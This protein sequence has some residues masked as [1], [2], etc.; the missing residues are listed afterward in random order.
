MPNTIING[1]IRPTFDDIRKHLSGTDPRQGEKH[2]RLD[3]DR[4]LHL[5]DSGKPSG[6]GPQALRARQEKHRQ[7]FH[8]VVEAIDRQLRRTEGGQTIHIGSGEDVLRDV[9][10]E[11]SFRERRISVNDLGRIARRLEDV[12]RAHRDALIDRIVDSFAGQLGEDDPELE[13]TLRQKLKDAPFPGVKPDVLRGFAKGENDWQA[14]PPQDLAGLRDDLERLGPWQA[15]ARHA[16]IHDVSIDARA[17]IAY[18]QLTVPD[19]EGFTLQAILDNQAARRAENRPDGAIIGRHGKI[20]SGGAFFHYTTH[21]VANCVET[22]DKVH[23]SVA[24]EQLARAWNAIAPILIDNPDAIKQFKVSDL[25]VARQEMARLDGRIEDMEAGRANPELSD[26]DRRQLDLYIASLRTQRETP[27]RVYEGAQITI[28]R[29][30][31]EDGEGLPP[32]RFQQFIAQITEAL[33][34]HHVE[35]GRRPA[36]DLPVNDF[37]TYRNDKTE[38]GGDLR[39]EDP[40]YDEHL[41]RMKGRPLYIALTHP[42]AADAVRELRQLGE[43]I[44]A[45]EE[46]RGR[47]NA[48]GSVTLYGSSRKPGLGSWLTGQ[49]ERR[50]ERARDEVAQM[51][52]RFAAALGPDGA[53]PATRDALQ[54]LRASLDAGPL[55]GERLSQA[56]TELAQTLHQ[57]RSDE[58]QRH[59]DEAAQREAE[60]RRLTRARG[61]EVRDMDGGWV[62]DGLDALAQDIR[63]FDRSTLRPTQ[64]KETGQGLDAEGLRDASMHDAISHRY[65]PPPLARQHV[66]D[67]VVEPG[68]DVIDPETLDTVEFTEIAQHLHQALRENAPDR[69]EALAVRLSGL[70]ARDLAALDRDSQLNL[71]L[72]NG[73]AIIDGLIDALE[74]SWPPHDMRQP[75]ADFVARAYGRA[76]TQL[77]DRVD[78]D[79]SVVV[80]GKTYA[81]QSTLSANAFGRVELYQAEDGTRIVLKTPLRN[82]LHTL[83]R[84]LQEARDEVLAH[85]AAQ[86]DGEDGVHPLIIGFRGAMRGP[87]GLVRIALE[88]AP[89]GNLNGLIGRIDQ[90]A[91]RGDISPQT[92][93]L[94]RITLLRDIVEGMRHVQEARGMLHLDLKP[95]NFFIGEDGLAKVG[96]FGTARVGDSLHLAR[97]LVDNPRW[98]APEMIRSFSNGDGL[99]VDGASDVWSLG[100]TAYQLFHEGALPFDHPQFTSP[101]DRKLIEFGASD[102]NRLRT[103]GLGPDG[104]PGRLGVTALDRLL[105]QM[106]HPNPELRSDLG[107]ILDSHLFQEPGVGGDDVRALIRALCADSQD[108]V[109]AIGERMGA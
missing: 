74:T 10:D 66:A 95:I 9:L 24:P 57:D 86:G 23:I 78:A 47:R 97:R 22:G 59:W 37:V 100:I 94:A 6:I 56:V 2:L 49:T 38:D 19:R 88:Y 98:Q 44:G 102:A 70:I 61:V 64:T 65:P 71:T 82:E 99:T 39:P 105:N 40:R 69:R 90:A 13:R 12:E 53:H 21:D 52:T 5:H 15:L 41:E 89:G 76:L 18:R 51:L 58:L 4:G 17:H 80:D 36:S 54:R 73:Q 27:E 50:R 16:L 30:R 77:S 14:H 109:R 11:R 91:R 108:E 79:G 42:Q 25:E 103:L 29:H 26:D 72:G 62:G 20:E 31:P 93:T 33:Q 96:D 3:D 7:A 87:D 107:Q 92:A 104:G 63:G 60:A 81:R 35:P 43:R 55:R 46:I 32:E 67:D 48:D 75:L 28:Y 8:Q 68:F 101:I 34:K 85:R 1:T 84:Q 45:G 83:E 106:L